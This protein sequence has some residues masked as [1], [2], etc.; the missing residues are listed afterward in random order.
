M[1]ILNILFASSNSSL[2]KP[3]S[4]LPNITA[5]FF[6]SLKDKIQLNISSEDSKNESL[7]TSILPQ[8]ART[9]SQSKIAF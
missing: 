9:K 4:S 5:R 1:V 8:V 6:I 7:L 2:V 3:L